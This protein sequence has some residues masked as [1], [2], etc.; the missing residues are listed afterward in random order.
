MPAL[1]P[2]GSVMLSEKLQL[3]KREVIHL[4]TDFIY[5]ANLVH[6]KILRSPFRFQLPEGDLAYI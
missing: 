5:N 1:L 2:T 6:S 4:C 3:L